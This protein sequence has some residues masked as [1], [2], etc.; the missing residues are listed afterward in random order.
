MSSTSKHDISPPTLD[1]TTFFHHLTYAERKP[2][3]NRKLLESLANVQ[4]YLRILALSSRST[5][6][7]FQHSTIA[8]GI[9]GTAYVYRKYIKRFFCG[10]R[11][12][13]NAHNNLSLRASVILR[14][15]D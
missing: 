10:N 8:S 2:A 5:I 4:Q 11:R 3:Q 6:L 15:H 7:C 14:K 9:L 1:V 12:Q 13:G